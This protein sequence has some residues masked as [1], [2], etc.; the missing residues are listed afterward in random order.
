MS[1]VLRAIVT[2]CRRTRFNPAGTAF[3][4]ADH[5]T[6]NM[7]KFMLSAATAALLT[8]TGASAQVVDSFNQTI[9]DA[10]AGVPASF[11][12]MAINNM[13]ID[14]SIDISGD[15][16]QAFSGAFTYDETTDNST[17]EQATVID[18][19]IDYDRLDI[20]SQMSAANGGA[21]SDVFGNAVDSGTGGSAAFDG[22]YTEI[23]EA[24]T[25]T[26]NSTTDINTATSDVSIA[27]DL[28][29][30]AATQSIGDVSSL[31]AGAVNT[32][33]FNVT[34][35]A[36]VL[37]DSSLA[38]TS[39]TMAEASSM[40]SFG[41]GVGIVSAAVNDSTNSNTD[42]LASING[43]IGISMAAGN[44]SV[45]SVDSVAAGAINT[46]DVTAIFFGSGDN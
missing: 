30:E 38:S 20:T 8:A 10:L 36:G 18:N 2:G 14:G 4:L 12:S 33:N 46:T 45:G 35:N 42:D 13:G 23:S 21:A 32:G 44:F 39:S 29:V 19:S 43:S 41:S 22:T 6:S 40:A 28:A 24:T 9:D 11:A 7:T 15:A 5:G 3:C 26:D 17:S 16:D 25:A 37:D 27:G 34:E 31:A 1:I